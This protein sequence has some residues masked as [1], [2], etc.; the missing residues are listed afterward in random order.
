MNDGRQDEELAVQSGKASAVMR[1]LH[2]SVVLQ[3]E[4][5]RKTKLAVFKSIFVLILTYGHERVRLLMQASEIKCSQKFK[6]V[7]MFDKL[8]NSVIRESSTWCR[9]F[10]GSQDRIFDG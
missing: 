4:L 7:K 6:N 10:F 3:R 9:P 5:L 8:R 2:H 1:G